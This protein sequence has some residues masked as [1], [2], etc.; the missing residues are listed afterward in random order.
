M[1][2]VKFGTFFNDF[3]IESIFFYMWFITA[4]DSIARKHTQRDRQTDRE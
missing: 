4:V 3:R 2:L 1:H